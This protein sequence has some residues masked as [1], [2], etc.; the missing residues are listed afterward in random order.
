MYLFIS[1]IY[2]YIFEEREFNRF[3]TVYFCNAGIVLL[4]YTSPDYILKTI[5]YIKYRV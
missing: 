1:A 5:L 3:L 2:C 4:T